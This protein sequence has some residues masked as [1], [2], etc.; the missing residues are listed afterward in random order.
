[1]MTLQVFSECGFPKCNFLKFKFKK[2]V[3]EIKKF[4]IK[5]S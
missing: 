2:I 4:L 3:N 1:M 5:L